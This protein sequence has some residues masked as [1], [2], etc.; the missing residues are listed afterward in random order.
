MMYLRI[1]NKTNSTINYLN[2]TVVVAANSFL[3]VD[4]I[5]WGNLVVDVNLRD[6]LTSN[7]VDIS[8]TISRYGNNDGIKQLDYMVGIRDTQ[9]NS[10]T[11]T[12]ITT[13]TTTHQG[14]DVNIISGASNGAPDKSAF[15]YG[16]TAFVSIGGVYN[17]ETDTLQEGQ[18]AVVRITADRALHTT[19]VN[20]SIDVNPTPASNVSTK[21]K[22]A[23]I[24]SI[25]SGSLQTLITYI[26]PTDTKTM[27][28]RVLV[29]GEVNAT[30]KINYNS[31]PIATKRTY[32]TALNEVFDF[33]ENSNNGFIMQPG[34]MIEITVIS[35]IPKIADYESTL[36][37]V[38]IT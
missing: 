27:L 26:V 30:Y 21:L 4:K 37:I 9:G 5:Y 14:M 28:Q 18:Q 24:K 1:Y 35:T 2:D 17:N 12:T 31:T 32:Y 13:Q 16:D 38:E 34:D 23:E 20:S 15:T 8:D 10:I 29:S 7:R 25:P 6:D 11:S 33:I 19:L 22:Y 36:Q 3:D